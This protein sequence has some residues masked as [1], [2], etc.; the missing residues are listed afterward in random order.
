MLSR[1]K[2]F[3]V[4]HNFP[5]QIVQVGELYIT[6]IVVGEIIRTKR[7]FYQ[8]SPKIKVLMQTLRP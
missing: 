5:R 2:H 6:F 4:C 7:D 1:Q 3:A 8:V